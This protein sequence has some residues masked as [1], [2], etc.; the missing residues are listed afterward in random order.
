MIEPTA[1]CYEFRLVVSG[2]DMD[3]E[4]RLGVVLTGFDGNA[5]VSAT[6][7][8][9]VEVLV[10]VS[11][12][13][14]MAAVDQAIDELGRLAHG[15]TVERVDEELVSTSDIAQLTKRTRESIRLLADGKRGNGA[16]PAPIG[17]IG[18]AIRVWRWV[19]VDEW[20]R[21]HAGYT[22]PTRPLP[23]WVIDTVNASLHRTPQRQS[24]KRWTRSRAAG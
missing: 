1:T 11:V 13:D 8:D 21:Q 16:F 10:T 5:S 23:S 22:F 2:L 17:V 12:D 15:V 4:S 9:L 18:S 20:L 3:D 6:T 19:D 24:S 7:T 14:P